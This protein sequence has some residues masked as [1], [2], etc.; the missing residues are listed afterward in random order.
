VTWGDTLVAHE[1][2]E[3]YE[4]R[5]GPQ[6]NALYWVAPTRHEPSHGLGRAY[7]LFRLDLASRLS[8]EIVAFAGAFTPRTVR[9]LSDR[10]AAVYGID[11]S[12]ANL[13]AG[14]PHVLTVDLERGQVVADVE[15][16]GVKD[17]QFREENTDGV[18]VDPASQA[19]L[20]RRVF[21][22]TW[23]SELLTA[24]SG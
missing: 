24:P 23:F 7:A 13:A 8:T 10:R 15:L 9:I 4:L 17:W 16:P 2:S 1:I 18:T 3:A 19:V 11:V 14:A 5:F 6:G 21:E 20:A 22:Q 12:A